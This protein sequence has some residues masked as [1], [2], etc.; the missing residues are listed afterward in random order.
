MTTLK[1]TDS[2]K[3]KQHKLHEFYAKFEGTVT[4][5]DCWRGA[6]YTEVDDA[7][8]SLEHLITVKKHR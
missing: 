1:A 4:S 3:A 8:E 6:S 7:S 5:Y 2:R